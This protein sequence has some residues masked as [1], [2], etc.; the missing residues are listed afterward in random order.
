[1]PIYHSG[2]GFSASLNS[3]L[4]QNWK[5]P[6]EVEILLYLNEPKGDQQKRTTA[7]I[8]TAQSF[9]EQQTPSTPSIQLIY[10]QLDGGLPEVY[11]RG[12]ST[13]VARI[14]RS[15]E[16][17]NLATKDEILTAIDAAMETCVFAVVDD[18]LIFND[19]AGLCAALETIEVDTSIVTGE[20]EITSVSSAHSVWNTLLKDTMNLFFRFK[21]EQG[22]ATLTPRGIIVKDMFHQPGVAIGTDY[23]DQVWFAMGAAHKKRLSIKTSTTLEDETYPSN[24]QMCAKLSHFLDTGEGD[25]CLRIFESVATIYRDTCTSSCA[26]NRYTSTDVESLI[27]TLRGRNQEEIALVLARLTERA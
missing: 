17:Q 20:I 23:A 7:S 27:T 2:D 4:A 15:I 6:E 14:Q 26:N 24:A 13:L 21:Q 1:M 18:D 9:V 16:K 12:F 3:L 10:E 5:N 19:P 8:A 22:S 11:Q 25:E